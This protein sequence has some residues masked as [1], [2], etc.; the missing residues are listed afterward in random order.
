MPHRGSPTY[1]SWKLFPAKELDIENKSGVWWN[2]TRESSAT[3]CIVSTA[4][5]LGTLTSAH[6]SDTFIPAL[7]LHGLV[8]VSVLVR[9][10]LNNLALSKNEFKW[11]ATI[12]GRIEFIS[13]GKGTSVMN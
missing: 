11:L 1:I 10:N 4:G 7:N 9:T 8:L 6:L 5:K 12:T 3:I 2:K 13:I